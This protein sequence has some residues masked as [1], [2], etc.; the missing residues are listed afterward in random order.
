MVL[1]TLGLCIVRNLNIYTSDQMLLNQQG[2][3]TEHKDLDSFFAFSAS[4]KW[5]EKETGPNCPSICGLAG[6]KP[7]LIVERDST[8]VS[9][10]K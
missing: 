2:E 4:M 1:I 5:Q 10:L 6:S 3:G 9:P 7:Q 8:R